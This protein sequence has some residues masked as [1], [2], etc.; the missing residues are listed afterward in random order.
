MLELPECYVLSSQ[1]KDKI[2][3]K[4]IINV[5]LNLS[6]HKF[7]WFSGSE[8][9]YRRMLTDRKITGIYPGTKYSLGGFREIEARE[10]VYK[11]QRYELCIC[12]A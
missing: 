10:D 4:R 1:L 5:F 9:D 7:A 6:P 3:G 8:D 11:R 2:K 12:V